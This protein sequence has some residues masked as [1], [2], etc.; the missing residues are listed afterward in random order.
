MERTPEKRERDRKHLETLSIGDLQAKRQLLDIAIRVLRTSD[1]P[2]AERAV[3]AYAQDQRLVNEVLVAKL[4]AARAANDVPEPEAKVV[5]LQAA[6]LSS[7]APRP[8]ERR[9]GHKGE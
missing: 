3:E 4:K 2:R 9:K 6:A 7:R 8:G 5:P 1:D